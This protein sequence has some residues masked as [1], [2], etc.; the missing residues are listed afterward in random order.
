MP[1][2]CSAVGCRGNY[3]NGPRVSVFKFPNQPDI[4]KQWIQFIKRDS[5]EVTKNSRV[6]KILSII[7]TILFLFMNYFIHLINKIL[8]FHLL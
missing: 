7:F 8:I 1:Y 4:R 3:D 2:R 5:F 6:S